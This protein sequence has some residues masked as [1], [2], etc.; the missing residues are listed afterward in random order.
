M[1]L[2]VLGLWHEA[3]TFSTRPVDNAA[4]AAVGVLRGQEVVARHAA[5]T[6]T[7]S[8][9]LAAA[10]DGVEVVPL[11]TTNLVP[12][13]RIAAAA[14]R[15][16]TDELVRALADNGP[17]DGVLVSLHGSAV[18][19][20]VLDVDGY[21]LS[22][23]RDVVGADVPI[24]VSLDLHANISADMCAHSD[25]LNTYRTN[26]HLDA[27]EAALEVAE[28]VIGAVRGQ[29]RPTQAFASVPAVVNILRQNTDESPMREIMADVR[30]VMD[31]PGVLSATV[32]E[33]YPYADVPEMGMAVV[34]VT[35]DD[36]GGAAR[37]ARELAGRVWAR[38]AEFHAS[39]PGPAEAVR[40]VVESPT[41]PILLL[42]V[43]DNIGGGSP[44]DSVV[45]LNAA[46]EAGLEDLLVIVADPAA[47]TLC[48]R[49][50]VGGTTRLSIGA[51]TDPRTGP[52]VRAIATVLAV[53]DGRYQA[54]E[55][56]HAGISHFDAGPSAAV[57]LDSGQTVVLTSKAVMPLSTAQLTTLGMKPLQFKAIVAKGVHSPLAGYGPH[58]AGMIRVDTP[59]V[60]SADLSRFQ[61]VYR[62][63]PLFPFES[64]STWD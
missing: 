26:P 54:A 46:R 27:K 3:N 9:Y 10:R 16:R 63:R 4:F 62:R 14:L 40:R 55:S 48:H 56:V 35:D 22:R 15:A 58:V 31:R 13:G 23:F 5:G 36:P 24:G 8:G 19:E 47:A 64:L 60:T 52:P 50:G 32:A 11:V 28:L 18:A 29:V 43:G 6:T 2:A 45:L 59:G 21:L 12:A 20:D 7:V 61:Y 25:V 17:F 49:V 51:K 1:R 57:K 41:A 34:V 44:G 42:D 38:R 30:A 53:H 33:G 37:H 39:A